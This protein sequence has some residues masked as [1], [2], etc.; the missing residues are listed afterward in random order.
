MTL[1]ADVGAVSG[2]STACVA[3]GRAVLSC[4]GGSGMTGF[5]FGGA[6]VTGD[7]PV[8]GAGAGDTLGVTIDATG[9]SG[10]GC[11]G[12]VFS[13]TRKPDCCH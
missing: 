5:I 1:L 3:G 7:V 11:V 9:N 10:S 2:F 8:A 13:Q 12:A 4:F 6:S